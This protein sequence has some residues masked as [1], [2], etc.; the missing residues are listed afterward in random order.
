MNPIETPTQPLSPIA[1]AKTISDLPSLELAAF[2]EALLTYMIQKTPG[3][4]GGDACIR[5][6]RIP[7]WLIIS[8]LQNGLNQ[9]D[10]LRNY[11]GL[12][13]FDLSI[14]Q[15]YYSLHRQEIDELIIANNLE[16]LPP[17][18]ETIEL[19][20]TSNQPSEK[21]TNW[22]DFIGQFEADPNLSV[23]Y[24]KYLLEGL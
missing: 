13:A 18:I 23:N 19:S 10:L 17:T 6:T 16:D 9:T 7:V 1:L 11:P 14:T 12:T 15:L 2:Q 21:L 24:K 3:V 5:H 20:H 22:S 4:C 8:F